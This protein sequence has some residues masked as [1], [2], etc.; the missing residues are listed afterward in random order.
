MFSA[1]FFA[2]MI[3]LLLDDGPIG[4]ARHIDERADIYINN[5]R[6]I[7]NLIID[8]QNS[9]QA[10]KIRSTSDVLFNYCSGEIKAINK[11]FKSETNR[12]KADRVVSIII[13]SFTNIDRNYA[14]NFVNGRENKI[15]LKFSQN[16][17]EKVE[18]ERSL[19]NFYKLTFYISPDREI[20]TEGQSI[21]ASIESAEDSYSELYKLFYNEMIRR[22]MI[23]SIPNLDEVIK[24]RFSMDNDVYIGDSKEF[25]NITFTASFGENQHREMLAFNM[26][27]SLVKTGNINKGLD[28]FS[29][30]YGDRQ[31][32][33]LLEEFLR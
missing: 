28:S 30:L 3:R 12:V 9:V 10:M 26:Y 1:F 20:R 18:I 14:T 23:R 24:Y 7:R 29:N 13:D 21:K 19:N 15:S 11:F 27:K 32:D 6:M 16:S 5:L 33:L 22:G 2:R 4:D 8:M 31:K 25:E 17:E